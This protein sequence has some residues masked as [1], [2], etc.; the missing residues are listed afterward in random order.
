[1]LRCTGLSKSVLFNSALVDNALLN[2]CAFSPLFEG[3][4]V[5]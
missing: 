5:N 3:F 1:M 4:S 2:K